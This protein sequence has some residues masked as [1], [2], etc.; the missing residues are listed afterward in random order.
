MKGTM[1][2]FKGIALAPGLADG[3]AFVFKPHVTAPV[4]R[5]QIDESHIDREIR[6]LEKALACAIEQLHLLKARV[7]SELGEAESL[8]F[9]AH[10]MFMQDPAF[11][12]DIR[13]H[14]AQTHC[15]AEYAVAEACESLIQRL[16]S[17]NTEYIRE[18]VQDVQDIRARLL[19]SFE[20]AGRRGAMPLDRIP[21]NTVIIAKDLLP[22]DTFAVNRAN[23]VAII[24]ETGGTTSHATILCRALGIPKVTGIVD[25][26]CRIQDGQRVLVD[27]DKGTVVISP[28]SKAL[29]SL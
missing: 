8:I 12:K 4:R 9:D 23:L 2:I 21:P 6:R 28:T 15:N 26:T 16:Q 10:L 14:I 17:V 29:S 19:R 22:S 24:T 5:E 20:A 13:R 3:T 1:K 25:A 11:V 7:L 27:A 18:R